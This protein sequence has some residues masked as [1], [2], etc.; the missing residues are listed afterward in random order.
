MSKALKDV[1][2][3]AWG[4]LGKGFFPTLL[5]LQQ[6][7]VHIRLGSFRVLAPRKQDTG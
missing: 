5:S 4:H 6:I 2:E 3:R 7:H 1:S